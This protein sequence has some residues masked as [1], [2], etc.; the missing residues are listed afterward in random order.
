MNFMRAILALVLVAAWVLGYEWYIHHQWA[1]MQDLYQASASLWRPMDAMTGMMNFIWA[2]QGL[3]ALAATL[4][5]AWGC[6]KSGLVEGFVYGILIFALLAGKLLVM[7]AVEPY[8]LDLLKVW[9]VTDLI[10]ALGVG[11]ILGLVYRPKSS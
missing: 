3:Y 4:L 2:G 7:Y 8:T 6:T 11:I 5:F 10:S 9:L 1:Y